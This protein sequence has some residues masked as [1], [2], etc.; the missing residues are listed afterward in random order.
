[1]TE[2]K[3]SKSTLTLIYFV[4]NKAAEHF[5]FLDVVNVL[6]FYGSGKFLWV[7]FTGSKF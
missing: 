2:R 3:K 1:M 7:L 4:I 5:S 6:F